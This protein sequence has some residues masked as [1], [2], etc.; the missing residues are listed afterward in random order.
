[1]KKD[2]RVLAIVPARGGSRSI[3]GKNI[4]NFLGKPL[5]FWTIDAAFKSGVLDRV[6]V[7]TDDRKIASIA[8]KFGAEIPFIRPSR[9]AGDTTPTLPVLQHAVRWLEKNESYQPDAVMLLEPVS[10]SRQPFHIREALHEFKKSSADSVVSVTEAPA[11]YN[12]HWLFK[13]NPSGFGELFTGEG[14]RNIIPRRQFLPK[15]HAK[16][17]AIYIMK[18][19]N[20]F[21]N[22]PSIFGK[23]VKLYVMGSQYNIDI[24]EP[25][26][27][28]RAEENV[29]RL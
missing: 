7:S 23:K 17:G 8:K 6:I 19:S 11:Q 29:K 5:I 2:F 16:N 27:W 15:V 18:P 12:P 25:E 1:M 28:H 9:L 3:P 20:L 13:K 24:D 22:P 26:D 10:P 14:A 4:K 21:Q